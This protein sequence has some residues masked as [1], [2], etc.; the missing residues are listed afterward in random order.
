MQKY[1]TT[2][3]IVFAFIMTAPLNA[4]K[5]TVVQTVK[6]KLCKTWNY[7]KCR[8]LGIEYVSNQDEKDD[9]LHFEENM[10][11]KMIEGGKMQEGTWAYT[12]D[13]DKIQLLNEHQEVV[14][15]LKVEKLTSTEFIYTV[16]MNWQYE[17]SMFMTTDLLN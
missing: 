1:I 13:L 12:A 17:V 8:I 15:E 11:Y 10:T 14:K 9:M 6:D 4:Q 5:K 2:L 7:S 3:L 16:T